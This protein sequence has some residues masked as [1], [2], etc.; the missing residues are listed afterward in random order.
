MRVLVADDHSLFRDGLVSLLEAGGFEV[1]GQCG[2]GRAAVEAALR[3][4]PDLVLLD[5]SMPEVTGLEA[6]HQIRTEWPEAKVVMLTASDNDDSLFQASEAGAVGYLLK[7][8]KAEEFLSM[9]HGVENGEAAMTRQTTARLLAG[10]TRS[11]HRPPVLLDT[12]TPQETRLLQL[13]A[14][15][16]SNKAIA[17]ALSLSENTVKY[18]LKNILQKLGLHNR[19]EAAAYAIRAGL[20]QADRTS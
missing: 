15:G 17:Q 5:I 1:V 2:D 12:L 4:R 6:L 9:L 13:L 7:S 18:H 10:L 8:L 11:V 16:L 3:L 19:T 20:Q 14:Q